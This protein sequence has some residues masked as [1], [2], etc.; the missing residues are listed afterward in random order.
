M[1]TVWS[2]RHCNVQTRCSYFFSTTCSKYFSCD[3][4]LA[5]YGDFTP[6][7]WYATRGRTET[8]ENSLRSAVR[9]MA[10]VA[11]RVRGESSVSWSTSWAV[12][13]FYCTSF[14]NFP[15]QMAEFRSAFHQGGGWRTDN[16][17]RQ[18]FAVSCIV[19]DTSPESVIQHAMR[20]R[21]NVMCLVRF[22]YIFQHYLIKG[23]IFEKKSYWTQNVSWFSSQRL[24]E[25]FLVPVRIERDVI[26][27]Q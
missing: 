3:K 9:A 24:S 21:N 18:H 12:R 2:V 19:H 1:K 17:D 26:K 14:F 16:N 23:I 11:L 13:T 6:S 8:N 10:S 7:S 20:M 15:P 27:T 22:H 5:S 4:Y 25:T